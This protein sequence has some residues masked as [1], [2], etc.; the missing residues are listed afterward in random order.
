M[1][2]CRLADPGVAM[3]SAT[4]PE[5][6]AATIRFA[7]LFAGLFQVLA[8]V[9]EARVAR[10]VG[11]VGDDRNA[12]LDRRFDRRV[13]RVQ[14]DQRDRDAVGAAGHRAV[15]RVDHLV[16]V[17]AFRAGPLVGAAEQ[18]RRVRR[19]VLRRREERVRRDVV[20]EHE[21][22]VLVRAEHFCR[23]R[24]RWRRWPSCCCSSRTPPAACRLSLPRRRSAQCGAG[25]SADRI[26]ACPT[27]A[28]PSACVET[29][30]G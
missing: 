22:V 7:H 9:R 2:G 29:L 8:D 19:A 24:R 17:R 23:T 14:V 13:E 11:V 1:R 5:P 20:D 4:S 10:R 6:T 27:T 28:P 26:P 30:Y 21:L 18:L 25:T 16:D 12:R 3:N 15:Q